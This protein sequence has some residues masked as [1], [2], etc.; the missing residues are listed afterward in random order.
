M[1]KQVLAIALSA[2]MAGS[3]AGMS[4]SAEEQTYNVGICQLVQHDALDAA[5]Q[6][7]LIHI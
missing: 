4:V 5:T 3:I 7:S 6:L 2:A 1:K